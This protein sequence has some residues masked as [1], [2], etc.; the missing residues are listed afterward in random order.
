MIRVIELESILISELQSGT[1]QEKY[2]ISDAQRWE[3][4]H[5]AYV[6]AISKL[7][8]CIEGLFVLMYSVRLA[9]T[10]TP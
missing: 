1:W 4:I 3:T 10:R 6:D 5:M 9:K 2:A 7:M 8:M